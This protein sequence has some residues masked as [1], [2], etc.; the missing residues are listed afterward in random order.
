MRRN[1]FNR[2]RKF[3]RLEDR[4]MMAADIDFDDGVV[5]VEGTDNRDQIVI[6]ANPKDSDEILVRVINLRTGELLEQ[7]DYDREDVDRIDAYG[8]GANDVILNDTDIESRQFGGGGDDEL[9]GGSGIDTL[10]GGANNDRL[11]GGRGNDTLTGGTGNDTYVFAGSSLGIDTV[12][13]AANVDVDTLDFSQ[14]TTGSIGLGIG[15]D[16]ASTAQSVVCLGN[17]S[18][19]LSSSSGI[20]NVLGTNYM[21]FIN[22][23][24]RN[25]VLKGFGGQDYIY[26]RGGADDLFG[27]A[28]NDFLFGEAGNDRLYGEAGA[29]NLDG[30]ADA[31]YLDGGYFPTF[32]TP[33]GRDQLTGGTGADTFVRHRVQLQPSLRHEDFRD[34]NPAIDRVFEMWH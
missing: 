6:S 33:T 3:E 27:G 7:E 23:N 12:N 22:G 25:N 29:D 8:F 30:G 31:D 16:L 14:I 32:G 13:E 17:L 19:R 2:V 11:E 28:G 5:T 1:K 9:Y 4:R 18:L 10:D 34:F 15:V 26:G 24:V 20:E 21:D